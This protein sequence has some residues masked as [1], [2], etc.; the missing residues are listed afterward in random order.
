M[1][2]KR[3]SLVLLCAVMVF[4]AAPTVRQA[5]AENAAPR[6]ILVSPTC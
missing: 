5:L 1:R 6:L 3:L 4:A 2:A